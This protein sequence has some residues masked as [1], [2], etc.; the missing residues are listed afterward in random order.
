MFCTSTSL[1][2]TILLPSTFDKVRAPYDTL[3][4]KQRIAKNNNLINS[5]ECLKCNTLKDIEINLRSN[6]I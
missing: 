4:L 5:D 3:L 2:R 6:I 1:C